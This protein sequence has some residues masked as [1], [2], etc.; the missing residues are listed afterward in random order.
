[1]LVELGRFD[2]PTA[3]QAASLCVAAGLDISSDSF[4]RA[5][6]S[7]VQSVRRGFESF[8]ATKK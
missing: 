7:A 8:A 1:L 5:L 4:G 2:E 6:G 3:A